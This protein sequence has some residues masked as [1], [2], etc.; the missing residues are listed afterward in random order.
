ME[1]M[2]KE[3]RTKNQLPFGKILKTIMTERGLTVRAIGEMAGVGPSVVQNWLT[4]SSPQDLQAVARLAKALNMSFKGL[5]LGE[6]E[7]SQSQPTLAELFEEQDLFEG[8][9]KLKMQRLVPRKG[10]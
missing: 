1:G 5:L 2:A 7:L 3:R 10:K 4:H 9:V 6:A 8:I